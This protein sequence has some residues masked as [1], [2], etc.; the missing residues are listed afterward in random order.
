MADRPVPKP[1]WARVNVDSIMNIAVPPGADLFDSLLAAAKEAGVRHA[2][3][4]S[5]IGAL[6]RSTFRNVKRY[7]SEFPVTDDE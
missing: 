3:I 1:T 5:G 7:P 2:T 4:I 6:G